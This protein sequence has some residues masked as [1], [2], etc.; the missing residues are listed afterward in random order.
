MHVHVLQHVDFED[1]GSI[2]TWARA[3]ECRFTVTGLFRSDPFPEES[4][5]DLLVIMGGPMNVYEVDRYP[6]L[7][8]EKHFIRGVIQAGRPVLGICLGAQLIAD[9]LGAAVES[10]PQREIGW[11]DIQATA[12]AAAHPLGR[13][14]APR[15]SV[16]HWHGD[17]FR[18]PPGAVHLAASAACRHQAFAWGERVLGLQFHLEMTPEGLKRLVRN[19][20][21]DLAAGTFVQPAATMLAADHPWDANQTLM[22]HLLEVL[23]GA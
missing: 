18:L 12:A 11:F 16:L 17:T 20:P 13:L 5:P 2:A 10:N 9:V 3:R 8:D 22:T 1:P 19:C 7:T 23:V 4:Q 6:W 14:L 15:R 21:A